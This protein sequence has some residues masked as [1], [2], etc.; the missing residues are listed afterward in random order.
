MG[1]ITRRSLLRG[2]FAAPAIVA[3]SSLMPI[4]GLVL[5]DELSTAELVALL[6][7]RLDAGHRGAW[8]AQS[9]QWEAAYP[10][11]LGY[12]RYGGYRSLCPGDFGYA[13][14]G[15]RMYS[16]FADHELNKRLNLINQ[17]DSCLK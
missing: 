6:D 16:D 3:A 13:G 7:G 17:G 15:F 12:V 1:L 9:R 14:D 11:S 5:A 4:R 2:L 10:G 8:N